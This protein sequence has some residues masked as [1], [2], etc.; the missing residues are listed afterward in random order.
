M[1]SRRG[2]STGGE[3]SH[4]LVAGQR[5]MPEPR[6]RPGYSS[7][8]RYLPVEHKGNQ[9]SSPAEGEAIEKMVTEILAAKPT[10]GD[11]KGEEKPVGLDDI[12]IIAHY[13]ALVFDIEDRI[14][15]A[16]CDRMSQR[17]KSGRRVGVAPLTRRRRARIGISEWPGQT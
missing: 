12:F 9:N 7:G 13:N 2:R 15:G 3:R 5:Q 16:D 17:T 6:G 1:G 8:L 14:P 4:A 11:R 10:W